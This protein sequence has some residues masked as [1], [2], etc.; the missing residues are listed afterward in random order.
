MRKPWFKIIF[1]IAIIIA[2]I[3]SVV[4]DIREGFSGTYTHYGTLLVGLSY[5]IESLFW[6]IEMWISDVNRIVDESL[7]GYEGFKDDLAN[8]DLSKW[9]KDSEEL[10]AELEREAFLDHVDKKGPWDE[11]WDRTN[12]VGGMT[13]TKESGF[14]EFQNKIDQ[15]K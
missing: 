2:S 14:K 9:I 4:T 11:E 3:P 10:E 12:T 6:V 15:N 8:E 7:R 13:N 5:F 1:S